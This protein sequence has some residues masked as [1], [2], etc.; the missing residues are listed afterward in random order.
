MIDCAHLIETFRREQV[1]GDCLLQLNDE[2]L[3][4]VF[5]VE[6]HFRRKLPVTHRIL[7]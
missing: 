2:R 4:Q 5:D 1:A 6:T 7:L 3:E